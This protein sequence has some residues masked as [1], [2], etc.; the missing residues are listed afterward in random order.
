MNYEERTF[1]TWKERSFSEYTIMLLTKL[2]PRYERAYTTIW[3]E[4][5]DVN[6]IIFIS[7]GTLVVGYELN[8]IKKYSLVMKDKAIVGAHD[9][10][11]CKQSQFVYTTLTNIEGFFIRRENWY[12]I[13]CENPDIAPQIILKIEMN[14]I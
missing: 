14:Y 9:V 11:F 8:R 10:T 7:K 6:D 3:D 13:L 12:E 1:L 5:D 4:L 2:E